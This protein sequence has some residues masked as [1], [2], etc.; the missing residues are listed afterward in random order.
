MKRTNKSFLL[1]L[2]ILFFQPAAAQVQLNDS[3]RI[4]LLTASPWYEAVYAY[5]GHTAIRV[6]DDSTGVDAVFNYGYFDSSQPNFMYHFIRGETDYVLGVITFDQFIA[7]YGYKGQEVVEQELN[8]MVDEKHDL[9][10]ALVIN[11]LPENRGY[12]Y[13]YFYDNCAT[14]PRDMVENYIRGTVEYPPTAEGQSFRDLI[15]E[16]VNHSRWTKFGIDL[17]IGGDADRD[18][19]VR[20]KMYIPSYLM[21]SFQGAMVH[22]EDTIRMPLVSEARV[23]LERNPAI[24]TPAKEFPLSPATTALVLLFISLVVSIVQTI[25]LDK[26]KLPLV[27][28]TLL[29][30][31]AGLGGLIVL[32]LMYFSEHPATNPNWNFAWLHPFALLA[33]FLFWSKRAS[34]I[35]YF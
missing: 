12:R 9:Y 26:T 16:H 32:V 28:D 29:F 34:G 21:N 7:E 19:N 3:A 10:E 15:H 8:L 18:I 30:G 33:V 20:E 14:R 17:V 2:L 4:T 5:F 31:V 13:N 11:A 6:Q 25:K 24:N 27:F 22:R 1:L 35:V 23:V